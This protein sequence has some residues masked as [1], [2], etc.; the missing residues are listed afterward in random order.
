MVCLYDGNKPNKQRLLDIKTKMKITPVTGVILCLITV[1]R[2]LMARPVTKRKIGFFPENYRFRPDI[3]CREG[4][5]EVTLTHDELE[6][7]R[8]SDLSFMEQAQAAAS[9]GISRGTYQRILN[10]AHAKIADALVNG[11]EISIS[12]GQY[13][14]CDCYA[15][16][17][18]CGHKWQAPCD[19]LFYEND[20]KCP[21][22]G[23]QNIGCSDG[24]GRCSLGEARHKKML[25]PRTRQ[26]YVK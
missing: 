2:N 16:C 13:S 11:R 5:K 24:A 18:G 21:E 8:L 1:E 6:S 15:H 7:V 10:S 26:K 14:L 9:M 17:S 3:C 20:G 4:K 25:D 12:G 22:C 19:A 23:S